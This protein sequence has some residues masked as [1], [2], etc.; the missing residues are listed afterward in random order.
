VVVRT[1]AVVASPP[2]AS[3]AGIGWE[4]G[5]WARDPG[6]LVGVPGDHLLPWPGRLGESEI[7]GVLVVQASG[8]RPPSSS[9]SCSNCLIPCLPGAGCWSGVAPRP[10]RAT[11]GSG[12]SRRGGVKGGPKAQRALMS[13]QRPL[14][15]ER[16]RNGSPSSRQTAG[17]WGAAERSGSPHGSAA[18]A[19]R[20]LRA[21]RVR[22]S[23]PGRGRGRAEVATSPGWP[24]SQA[25][26][27]AS[28]SHGAPAPSGRPG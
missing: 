5:G 11:G 4:L 23:R 27:R 2:Q 25:A 13:A 16:G 20:S 8:T 21:P 10:L 28:F 6:S 15:P 9:Q 18:G 17:P 22:C 19:W 24:R 3:S 26:A 14:T 7:A 12:P 1:A